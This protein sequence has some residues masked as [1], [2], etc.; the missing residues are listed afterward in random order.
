MTRVV[1][2]CLT[3]R[4]KCVLVNERVVTLPITQSSGYKGDCPKCNTIVFKI[5]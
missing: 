1:G 2:Y 5:I 3:C 4:K